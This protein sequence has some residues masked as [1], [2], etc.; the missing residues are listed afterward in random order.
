[1]I[2]LTEEQRD[3]IRDAQKTLTRYFAGLEKGKAQYENGECITPTH[4]QARL[5]AERIGDVIR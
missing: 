3:A 1:M 4:D 5:A 2:V